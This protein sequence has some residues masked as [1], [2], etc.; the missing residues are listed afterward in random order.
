MGS[1]SGAIRAVTAAAIVL[2][3]AACTGLDPAKP[4]SAEPDDAFTVCEGHFSDVRAAELDT[5]G[6]VRNLG[7]VVVGGP[8]Q[9]LDA[10]A[11]DEPLVLCVVPS[12]TGMYD[13]IAVIL[14][15]GTTVPRWTSSTAD[16]DARPI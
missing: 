9:P 5:V 2:V 4:A 7:P 13:V 14:A 6:G 15:D 10:Y 1:G 11:D 3:S 16:L 12:E 8:P